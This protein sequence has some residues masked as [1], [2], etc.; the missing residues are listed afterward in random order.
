VSGLRFATLGVNGFVGLV[1][2]VA[3]AYGLGGPSVSW[4]QDAGAGGNAMQDAG[5]AS[6]PAPDA[7]PSV[8]APPTL[9]ETKL[10]IRHFKVIERDSGNINYYEKVLN[11]PEGPMLRARYRA[12]V[13]TAVLGLELP[14][15]LRSK[16]KR[17]HWRWRVLVFPVHGN[18]CA[19]GKGDS[20]ASVFVTFKRGLKY[21]VLKYSWSTD[22]PKGAV[23]DKRRG[24]FF[25]RDTV[26]LE[27]DG[28]TNVWI[29]EEMNPRT[30]FVRHFGGSEAEVPDFVGLGVMTDGDQTNS[31]A[32]ADYADFSVSS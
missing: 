2:A 8:P 10:D 16:A 11:D 30:E 26:I 13:D 15:A 5:A 27:S 7:G 23:C 25:V 17:V 24:P 20:A 29:D 12:G 14:E 28:P 19:P 32:Q 18:E 6:P 22:G 1:T 4:A 21:Y 31:P 9:V 3:V